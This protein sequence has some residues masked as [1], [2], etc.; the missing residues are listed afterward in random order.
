M[1]K[2]V[3]IK[4]NSWDKTYYFDPGDLELAKNDYVV[5]E[6]QFGLDLGKLVEFKNIED[7]EL[8]ESAEIKPVLRKANKQDL[9]KLIEIKQKTEEAEALCKKLI[10]KHDLPIKLVDVHVHLDFGRMTFAFIA[11]G[12][13]DFRELL[14][15]LNKNYKTNIRLQQL[16]IRDESKMLA[17]IGCCGQ[18]V[19]CRTFLKELGNVTSEY[20]EMQQVSHRGS[21]R[22]SGLCG[23][24]KCCLAY[25]KDLYESLM[26]KFP[27]IGSKVKTKMGKGEVVGQHILKETVDVVLADSENH[28][29][30]EIKLE[31][32]EPAP[33]ERAKHFIGKGNRH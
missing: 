6:T 26:K 28:S 4:F 25:E 27:A 10:K 29:S 12:R 13:V 14:K 22:L 5:V 33:M 7:T 17:D 16:G 3:G 2:V 15:D 32:I 31:D 11:D 19:C 1:K 9:D 8:K 18:K 20:A 21:E 23:R 24:L 30:V